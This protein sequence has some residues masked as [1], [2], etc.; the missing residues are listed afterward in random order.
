MVSCSDDVRHMTEINSARFY[1]GR[2]AVCRG[3]IRTNL[4]SQLYGDPPTESP[5]A[6]AYI[7]RFLRHAKSNGICS[8][9][10]LSLSKSS[11][12]LD[13]SLT[14]LSSDF[15]CSSP[16]SRFSEL[17]PDLLSSNSS[18]CILTTPLNSGA[19]ATPVSSF[20]HLSVCSLSAADPASWH[21][22]PDALPHVCPPRPATLR[23]ETLVVLG[24]LDDT[25]ILTGVQAL[26]PAKLS[27]QACASMPLDSLIWF[28]AAVVGNTLIVTGG[29][30]AGSIVSTVYRYSVDQNI[31]TAGHSMPRP[32]AR[33]ASVAVGSSHL[34][35]FGGVTVT[36][37]DSDITDALNDT[38]LSNFHQQV[39]YSN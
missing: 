21:H 5:E 31:W 33:H 19:G 10:P 22:C 8:Q 17:S 27:W 11:T 26:S 39:I 18:T 35:L 15:P 23:R 38:L 1:R 2:R 9:S 29:I 32:R 30:Q 25:C 16:L 12:H 28:S 3:P 24:G 13:K 7:K 36:S 6:C 4:H 14:I 34:F 37:T 20:P